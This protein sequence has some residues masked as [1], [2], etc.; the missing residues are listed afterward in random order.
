MPQPILTLTTDFGLSDHYVG[1]M[2]GVILNICPRAQIVDI[3]HQV[4]P[5]GIAQGAYLIAQAYP[6]FPPKT[7]HVIVVDPG[8]GSE[9]RPILVE[10]AGQYFVAP[11]NGVL[12]MIFAREKHTARIISNPRYF[13]QPVSRTFHGRDIFSP[14]AAHVAAGVPPRR[15][16]NRIDDYIRP[17]F[18]APAPAGKGVWTGQVLHV[19]RFGNLITNFR[20]GDFP[21]LRTGNFSLSVGRRRTAM[22]AENYAA[23]PAG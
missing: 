4:A 17:R 20:A 9:R 14:A 21:R 22:L 23:R 6:Y 18:A 16:G 13:L 12:A 10:A 8:V 19:D 15:L 3:S 11:D 1:T 7:V 5:F 2:K